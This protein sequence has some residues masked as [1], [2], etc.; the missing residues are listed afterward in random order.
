MNLLVT[1][2]ADRKNCYDLERNASADLFVADDSA[3]A[4]D[5]QSC[6]RI[7]LCCAELRGSADRARVPVDSHQAEG[8]HDGDLGQ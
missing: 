3:G 7:V 6:C 1:F 4:V 8:R 5:A 2:L